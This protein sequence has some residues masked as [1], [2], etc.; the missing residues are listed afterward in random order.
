MG[1]GSSTMST[2]AKKNV[3]ERV[4]QLLRSPNIKK[5]AWYD[6]AVAVP[7]PR[8]AFRSPK[9]ARMQYREEA[10]LHTFFQRIGEDSYRFIHMP[11]ANDDGPAVAFVRRQLELMDTDKIPARKAFDRVLVEAETEWKVLDAAILLA[12]DPSIIHNPMDAAEMKEVIDN[13]VNDV[14]THV[15]EVY[16][17][18]VMKD[19]RISRTEAEQQ[20]VKQMKFES[21][22]MYERMRKVYTNDHYQVVKLQ[23]ISRTETVQLPREPFN[24][25]GFC[26]RQQPKLRQSLNNACAGGV[27]SRLSN[28]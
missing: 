22:N 25:K 12:G 18:S 27:E 3:F 5:P 2:W 11:G 28:S 14:A 9:P 21:R 17:D 8:K 20:A 24:R 1:V 16:I 26:Q 19:S 23:T 15:T 13:H 4:T 7:P 6:A 10:L